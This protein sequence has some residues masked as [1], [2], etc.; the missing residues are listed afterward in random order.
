VLPADPQAVKQSLSVMAKGLVEQLDESHA[1]QQA[2]LK[3]FVITRQT[4]PARQRS[5][6]TADIRELMDAQVV[7]AYGLDDCGRL[8]LLPGQDELTVPAA[9]QQMEVALVDRAQTVGISLVSSRPD[10][11]PDLAPLA[12]RC[13]SL[14]LATQVLLVKAADEIRG[15]FAVHWVHHERPPEARRRAFYYYWD[16][17]SYAVAASAERARIETRLAELHKR[18]YFD[19][20]TGLPS[21]LALDDQ[22]RDHEDTEVLSVL[23][24][25]FDGMREANSK[26]G[27]EEGGDVLIRA[28]GE[29][30]ESLTHPPEFPARPHRGG[31][32]FAVILPGVDARAAAARAAEIERQLDA[33]QVP[34]RHQRLYHGAS[35]GHATRL[36]DESPGKTLGRAIKAM[37]EQK[38]ARRRARRRR[39][40]LRW[41]RRRP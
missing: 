34:D 33:L 2:V 7:R 36:Q 29:A 5:M 15:A 8:A 31:D 32:E 12:A 37:S 11:D 6:I 30:L 9:G 21:Q 23:Y 28:V 20:K 10:L 39:A 14:G 26:F 19:E 1:L 22:L 13:A 27:Y 3:A 24:L 4:D 35:V 25:D 40:A 16:M 41:W 38:R 17:A 18:A